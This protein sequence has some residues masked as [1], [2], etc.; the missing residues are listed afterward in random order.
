MRR[1]ALWFAVLFGAV[2]WISSGSRLPLALVFPI[3]WTAVEWLIGHQG[4]I[5]FP[6]LGLTAAWHL[7]YKQD[8][9]RG[10]QVL[11]QLGVCIPP[12]DRLA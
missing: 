3:C 4:D 11:E 2:G 7:K 5:R 10:R 12:S 8:V 6:W 9:A 1:L